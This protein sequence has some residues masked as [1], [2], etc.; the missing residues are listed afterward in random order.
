[1]VALLL[2]LDGVPHRTTA[3]HGCPNP[4][5]QLLQYYNTYFQYFHQLVLSGFS[6]PYEI[7]Y[8]LSLL[9]W[10]IPNRQAGIITKSLESHNKGFLPENICRRKFSEQTRRN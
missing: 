7:K 9:F 8:K 5:R 3:P 2:L 1:M 4:D 10:S 6:I